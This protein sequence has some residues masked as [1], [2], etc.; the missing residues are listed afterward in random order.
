MLLTTSF[1]FVICLFTIL[2]ESNELVLSI[3]AIANP[4]LVCPGYG[5]VRPEEPYIDECKSESDTCDAGIKCCYTPLKP[6]GYHCLVGK[7]N[8]A[9]AG[10]CPPQDSDQDNQD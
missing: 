1:L 3:I 2:F 7:D 5:F 9:K 4:E 10:T 6:C 8:V